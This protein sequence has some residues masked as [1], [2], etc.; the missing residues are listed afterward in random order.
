M[1]GEIQPY[2]DDHNDKKTEEKSK[3]RSARL[4]VGAPH[5]C[6]VFDNAGSRAFGPVGEER[7][8]TNHNNC[9]SGNQIAPAKV[10]DEKGVQLVRCR[11]DRWMDS[12]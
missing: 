4:T 12:G 2:L 10:L 3:G 8:N 9:D 5:L 7:E 1:T 11:H 6:V